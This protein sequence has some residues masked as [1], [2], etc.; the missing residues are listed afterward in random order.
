MVDNTREFRKAYLTNANPRFEMDPVIK[1]CANFS[2]VHTGQ[3]Y[4]DH[5]ESK[6]E[7]MR[8]RA[9]LMLEDFDPETDI[10]L[11]GG[12]PVSIAIC[13]AYLGSEYEGFT[14]GKYDRQEGGYY[15]LR[16]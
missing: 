16:I 6:I 13:C 14:I 9:E 15:F 4:P 1:V 2:I 10:L 7:Q 5:E 8:D 11:L 12:D 3:I